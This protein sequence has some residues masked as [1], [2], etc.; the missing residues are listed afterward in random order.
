MLYSER[1]LKR[2]HRPIAVIRLLPRNID[3][4]GWTHSCNDHPGG[5][6]DIVKGL[7]KLI[8]DNRQETERNRQ[9][10]DAII[11]ALMECNLGRMGLPIEDG[12]LG[13]STVEALAVYEV[14]AEAE[15]SVA[16]I[17]WNSYLPCSFGRFLPRE[18]REE[19]F[20]WPKQDVHKL[21][22]TNGQSGYRWYGV[23]RK[24]SMGSRVRLHACRVDTRNVHGR[25]RR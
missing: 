25:G 3:K 8:L 20:R 9:V 7:R 6:L 18:T 23:H 1:T 17:V 4:K 10:A 11:E 13:V 24:R 16:W 15:A 12:G 14:L 21:N 22:T 2:P 19:V 5:T